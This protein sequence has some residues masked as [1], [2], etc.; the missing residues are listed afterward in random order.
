MG[1]KKGVRRLLSTKEKKE[2]DKIVIEKSNLVSWGRAVS[3]PSY[4]KLNVFLKVFSRDCCGLHEL[5][6]VFFKIDLSDCIYLCC[7]PGSSR[8]VVNSNVC[9]DE[10]LIEKAC[11][12]FLETFRLS[13]FVEVDLLKRIPV[14]SG[15]GGG[16]SNVATVLTL[17][18]LYFFGEDSFSVG[19][20][21]FLKKIAF[22]V[23]SD[24]PFFLEKSSRSLVYDYGQSVVG[25]PLNYASCYRF[26]VLVCPSISCSTSYVYELFSSRRE[27]Q[28]RKDDVFSCY[29]RWP[30]INYGHNCLASVVFDAY[31]ELLI[32]N[33]FLNQLG[34]GSF[35][36]LTGSGSS[37]YA[38]F[39]SEDRARIVFESLVA[40]GLSAYWGRVF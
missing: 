37:F 20:Q 11:V 31:P 21:I 40:E 1:V 8:V 36:A 14:G 30:V 5:V 35:F 10:N 32:L 13:A 16:S 29:D 22:Q 23:G 34:L 17:L 39:E 28:C 33:R 24:V 2:V 18:A 25:L 3:L 15:L 9:F 38:L 27:Y 26:Y 7:L 6:S 19:V 12:L 4:A